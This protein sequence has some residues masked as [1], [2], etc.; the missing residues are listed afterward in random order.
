MEASV[1]EVLATTL[2]LEGHSQREV[3]LTPVSACSLLY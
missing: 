2:I 1:S 3:A